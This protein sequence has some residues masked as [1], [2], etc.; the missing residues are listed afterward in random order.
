MVHRH[1]LQKRIFYLSVL[2]I[3]IPVAL[4]TLFIVYSTIRSAQDSFEGYVISSM[5][6]VGA[7]VENVF[8]E[9]DRSSL[10]IIS[11]YDITSYLSL[12]ADELY[13]N[14]DQMF[15]AFNYQRNI[16]LTE[17]YVSAIQIQGFNS[18]ALSS[19]P[20]PMHITSE[21]IQFSTSLGGPA[22]WNT[23]KDAEGRLY[24]YLCRLLR[25]PQNASQQ[26][27]CV[28]LYLDTQLL[29]NLLYT[30]NDDIS[31]YLMDETGDILLCVNPLDEP[32][33]D[34]DFSPAHLLP[35]S[36]SSFVST[37]GNKHYYV[38]P[39]TI[40]ANGWTLCMVSQPTTVNQQIFTS[41]VLL[42]T[43]T[44]LCLVLCL[45][46]GNTLSR[47]TL[48]PLHEIMQKMKQIENENFAVR[49]EVKDDDEVAQLST[50]FNRMATK[51]NSLVDEVYKAD[52]RKK[53]AELR[54]LQAQF[55]PH[56]LYNTLDIVYWTAKME[57]A[58]ETSDLISALSLFFRSALSPTGEFTTVKNEL[59]HLRYY[60]ILRQQS[61]QPFDF[62]L[63]VDPDTPECK[64]VKLVLQPLV[65]NAII[66]GI[67]QM[68]NGRVDVSIRHESDRLVYRIQDNGKGVDTADMERLMTQPLES[69]RGFG[70]RNV[71]DRIQLVFGPRY[72]LTFYNRPEGGT[73]VTVIFPYIR[74]DG[75]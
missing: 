64:T 55:N 9:M 63:Q 3:L 2:L 67:G 21:D 33:P 62:N 71:N 6:K 49:I 42:A 52:I 41:I 30:E 74:E 75:A 1:T 4:Y 53:E 27:G 25:H 47:R 19:G 15:R 44:V 61:K 32:L 20:L 70:I 48:G 51:I 68:E 73:V 7:T 16:S 65:E 36:G 38:A 54:A 39:H 37:I 14:P 40:A 26:L 59:E 8:S 29:H 69:T 45:L 43:L 22:F 46:L 24:I 17:E 5:K 18:V 13:Q 11:S 50:Q 72:G 34:D 12:P 31:Y 35:K 56:F 66:H 10:F 58:P 57:N 23:E 60:V 28:K